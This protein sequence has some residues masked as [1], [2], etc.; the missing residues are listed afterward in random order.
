MT[1]RLLIVEDEPGIAMAL[2]DELT[3]HGYAVEIVNDGQAAVEAAKMGGFDALVLDLMLPKKDGFTVCREL[4]ECGVRTPILML[5][6]RTQEQDTVRGLEIGADDYLTKPYRPAELR[7]RINALLRR[8]SEPEGE[9]FAFGDIT[10][11]LVRREVTRGTRVVPLTP[12]E[13]RL[14]ESLIRHRGRALGRQRLID[15]AWGRDTFVTDRV[16]DNQITNLRKKVEPNPAEPRYILSIRGFGY[17]F[18][19]DQP[20]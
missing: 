16:V 4:R 13:F 20:M 6:A 18:D 8:H 11:N 5:T 1:R 2:E 10:V 19:G 7:A 9:V 17:R 14:L 12:Q 3:H 15:E